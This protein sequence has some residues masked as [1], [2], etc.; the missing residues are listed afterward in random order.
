MKKL[1]NIFCKSKK[2]VVDCFTTSASV[3]EFS[4]PDYTTKFLPDWWKEL[5]KTYDEFPSLRPTMKS[6]PGFI[7]LYKL[8]FTLPLWTDLNIKFNDDH[9]FDWQFADG[10]TPCDDHNTDQMTNFVD[11]AKYSHIKI[12]S[13][14]IIQEKEGILFH[15]SHP[16]WNTLPLAEDYMVAT[17]VLDFK[18]Q[19]QTNINMFLRSSANRISIKHGCPMINYFPMDNRMIELKHHLISEEEFLK[20]NSYGTRISFFHDIKKKKSIL[21]AKSH[22]CMR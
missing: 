6:C 1:L 14:W 20:I 12:R 3:Y 8:G 15:A 16:F 9:T 22:K 2:I 18:H 10:C 11:F 21:K 7:D 13:P 4:K 19:A 17:G 5:P